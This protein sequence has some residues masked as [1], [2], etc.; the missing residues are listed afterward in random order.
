MFD[1]FAQSGDFRSP[2][3]ST[4]LRRIHLNTLLH[5]ITAASLMGLIA[6]TAS[7]ADISAPSYEYDW[8]GFYVGAHGGYMWGEADVTYDGEPGGGE[9]DG[10][11]AV[12]WRGSTTSTRRWCWV[13]RGTVGLGDV[14]GKGVPAPQQP[15]EVY[16]YS[17]DLD[18]NVH[19][20]ARAGFAVDKALFFVAGGLAVAKHTLGVEETTMIGSVSTTE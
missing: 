11:G 19:L 16:D 8:S 17:Y 13:W 18:W 7:A 3:A 12:P 9:L 10:S 1:K 14:N 15:V 2:S 20:R 4:S 5:T 6:G